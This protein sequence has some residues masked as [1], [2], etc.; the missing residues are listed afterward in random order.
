[1]L[2]VWSKI[3]DE[4]TKLDKYKNMIFS[5]SADDAF[6]K[7]I[8][9]KL[10]SRANAIEIFNLFQIDEL[11]TGET[12][13]TDYIKISDNCFIAKFSEELYR[14]ISCSDDK[15]QPNNEWLYAITFSYGAYIFG[16]HYPTETFNKFFD[17]LKTYRPSYCDTV[18]HKMY[19]SSENASAIHKNYKSIFEKYREIASEEIKQIRIKNLEKELENLR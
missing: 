12:S 9:N 18:S 4:I 14:T 15:T 11:N 17:E 19:F 6:E 3:M 1:M 16:D 7:D 2:K 13:N 8:I 10:K 5:L